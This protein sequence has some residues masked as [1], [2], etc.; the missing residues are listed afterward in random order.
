MA[1]GTNLSLSSPWLLEL[2]Q[3][4]NTGAT[5]P[6]SVMELRIKSAKRKKEALIRD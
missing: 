2:S 5:S 4:G 3:F 1:L 6:V